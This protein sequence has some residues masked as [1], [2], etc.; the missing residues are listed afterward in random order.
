VTS[1]PRPRTERGR[2]SRQRLLDAA[3]RVF[4]EKGYFAASISDITREAGAAQGTFYVYYK[5][6]RDVFR[7]LLQS[8]AHLI[9][10]ATRHATVHAKN[11]VEAEALGLT[12][13]FAFVSRHPSLYRIVRQAEFV[14]AEGFR[15]YYGVFVSPWVRRVREAMARG[16]LRRMD[17]E[18]L[19]YCLM[20]IAD[21]VGMRWPYWTRRPI[22]PA[23]LEE[24][25]QFVRLG[26][27][28]RTGRPLEHPQRAARRTTRGSGKR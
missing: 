4:A 16:D 5:S 18:T 6:K 8:L 11:R 21:F 3:E 12:A 13:Y 19:V 15:S 20:G 14:D 17:P 22:P 28:P 7:E 24:T 1:G 26:L 25:M 23:V 27:E 10:Q 2:R 9:L